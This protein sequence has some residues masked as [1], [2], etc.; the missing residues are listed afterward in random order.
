ML[1]IAGKKSKLFPKGFPHGGR[2]IFQGVEHPVGKVDLHRLTDLSFFAAAD[3]RRKLAL[4]DAIASSRLEWSVGLARGVFLLA[5]GDAMID[6]PAFRCSVFVIC[7]R[8]LWEN[9]DHPTRHFEFEPVAALKTCLSTHG[10]WNHKRC[11]I[12]TV[13]VMGNTKW[14][15]PSV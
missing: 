12:F 3:L 13:M 10:G 1:K 14:D 11:P 9:C 2:C 4:S 8:R 15:P 7:G 6:G 5:L